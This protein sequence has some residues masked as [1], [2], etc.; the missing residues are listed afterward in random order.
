MTNPIQDFK[1]IVLGLK[2]IK[3]V[4]E[5]KMRIQ[6][7]KI[8]VATDSYQYGKIIRATTTDQAINNETPNITFENPRSDDVVI[9]D[10]SLIPST[11]F[12]TLGRMKVKINEALFFEDNAVADY[13]DVTE[14]IGQSIKGK[15][16]KGKQKIE[17]FMWSSDGTEIGLTMVIFIGEE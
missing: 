8:K 2:G 3:D 12:K 6:L 1:D 14:V 9:N 5:D 13:T 4:L 7:V 16:L 15:K 10:I 17:I 11:N